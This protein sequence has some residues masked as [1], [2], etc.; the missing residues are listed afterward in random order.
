ML[1]IIKG[2]LYFVLPGIALIGARA[3]L[4]EP[5]ST[6]A[7][8]LWLL[9]TALGLIGDNIEST[10]NGADR[11]GATT[12]ANADR[13]DRLHERMGVQGDV[14]AK[15]SRQIADLPLEVRRE[16]ASFYSFE[17]R[18]TIAA[19]AALADADLAELRDGR[20]PSIGFDLRL[21][22]LQLAREELFRDTNSRKDTP[23]LDEVN[24][25]VLAA[26]YELRIL[27][28][29]AADRGADGLDPAETAY[30]GQYVIRLNTW[31]D[32][33]LR[34]S[35]ENTDLIRDKLKAMDKLTDTLSDLLDRD[36]GRFPYLLWN[37]S[38]DFSVLDEEH[39]E[40]YG[41]CDEG[42][43]IMGWV[44][45]PRAWG[46]SI[47]EMASSFGYSTANS[48]TLAKEQPLLTDYLL[49]VAHQAET[50]M[51]LY[52]INEFSALLTGKPTLAPDHVKDM[53]VQ[54]SQLRS[55]VHRQAGRMQRWRA[56]IS[57]GLIHGPYV[58]AQARIEKRAWVGVWGRM[59][60]P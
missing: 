19:V 35:E 16:I 9:G 53:R 13:L 48:S 11:V 38:I 54:I 45:A 18:N 28:I 44:K 17:R 52:A 23:T 49:K 32:R 20:E 1:T 34:Q 4:A 3:A 50:A 43:R 59:Q 21:T 36:L 42:Y 10:A 47:E 25:L 15:I 8:V 14:L 31:S 24:A 22:Q 2:T 60:C 29:L 6:T 40:A 51:S 33:L 46:L 30:A 41:Q 7:F 56:A 39:G 12:L 26:I 27:Q 5:L 37:G 57:T 58:L 55:S